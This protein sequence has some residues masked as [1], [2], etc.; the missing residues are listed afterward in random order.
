MHFLLFNIIYQ[1]EQIRS[2]HTVMQS[3]LAEGWH[4][5]H[6]A[7]K[8]TVKTEVLF[9]HVRFVELLSTG[10]FVKYSENQTSYLQPAVSFATFSEVWCIVAE[11]AT[12]KVTD[13][14]L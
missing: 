11:K 12:D 6:I 5:K 8:L 1:N 4:C 3:K 10:S 13:E 7:F 2:L 9:F 14:R